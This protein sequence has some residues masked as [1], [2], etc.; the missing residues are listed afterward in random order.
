MNLSALILKMAGWKVEINAPDFPKCIICVAPHTS[1]WD[2]VYC[3]LAYSS[4]GRTANFLMKSDWFFFPLGCI[5][6]AIGGIPV[7]RKNKKSSLVEA[8]VEK[9][10]GT[11]TLKVA[12][13]PEGTRSRNA[14]WKTGFLR[15]AL[16]ANVPILLAALD[17]KEK[18]VTIDGVFTP[19]EDIEADMRVIKD[20]YKPY[21]AKYPQ[22]FVTD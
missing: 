7:E 15:I 5:F 1:N 10:N 20:F 4:V 21:H 12:I 3:K 14:D 22:K 8:V 18:K 19:S 6:R 17:Y 13:T 11:Q 2:F 9:L 16:Q